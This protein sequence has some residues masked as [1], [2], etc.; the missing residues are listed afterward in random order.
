MENTRMIEL[1]T[2]DGLPLVDK[3]LHLSCIEY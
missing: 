2:K 1:S 3:Y